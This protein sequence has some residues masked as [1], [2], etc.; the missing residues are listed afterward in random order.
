MAA[1]RLGTRVLDESEVLHSKPTQAPAPWLSVLIGSLGTPGGATTLT[2]GACRKD[3]A[4][5]ANSSA[6]PVEVKDSRETGSLALGVLQS[7]Q[8]CK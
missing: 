7:N 5:A 3:T 1:S 8:K 6:Q 2:G 4:T